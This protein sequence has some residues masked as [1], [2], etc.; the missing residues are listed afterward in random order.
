MNFSK[1]LSDFVLLYRERRQIISN[2]T[3]ASFR[4]AHRR[5]LDC[6]LVHILSRGSAG[7]LMPSPSSIT[8]IC[9]MT[10]TATT[11]RTSGAFSK[12][13]TFQRPTSSSKKFIV[14]IWSSREMP[15]MVLLVV[16]L[17]PSTRTSSSS[18][19]TRSTTKFSSHRCAQLAAM[20]WTLWFNCC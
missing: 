10:L 6:V 16:L 20:R 11:A 12:A 4:S 13:P 14:C 7:C 18:Q 3:C 15:V 19:T 9:S 8:S 17:A 1:I 5:S 2:A